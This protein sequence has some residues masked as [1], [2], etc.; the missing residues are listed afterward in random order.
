MATS[1]AEAAE[2]RKIATH[3][4]LCSQAGWDFIPFGMDATGALGSKATDLLRRLARATSMKTGQPL[5]DILPAFHTAL[6]I[7]LAKG[8]GEMLAAS[9]FPPC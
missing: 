9:F 7:A 1:A 8:R 5:K 6:S 2:A 4:T 3:N